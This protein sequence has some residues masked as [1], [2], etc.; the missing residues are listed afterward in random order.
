M[1]LLLGLGSHLNDSYELTL[2]CTF[3]YFGD[4]VGALLLQ[5]AALIQETFRCDVR[6]DGG[7]FARLK[8]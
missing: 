4:R 7:V 3:R 8:R 1:D 5:G 6:H 2:G